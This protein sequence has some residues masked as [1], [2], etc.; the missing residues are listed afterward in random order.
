MINTVPENWIYSDSLEMLFLFYQCTDELL[1]EISPDTY[2]LPQHNTLSLFLEIDE[3]YTLLNEYNIIED[4]YSNY[5]P[6]IIDE[7]IYNLEK[8][9]LLKKLIGK[10]IFTLK[11]G[12][13]EAKKNHVL[14]ER[15]CNLFK[16][17][18][19]PIEYL[20]MYKKE[21][22]KLVVET[23]EKDYLY[24]CTKNLYVSLISLGY[25]REYL[26]TYSKKFFNNKRLPITNLKQIEDFLLEFNV[27]NKKFEFLVLMD[28]SAIEYIDNLGEGKLRIGEKLKKID[29]EDR[30]TYINDICVTDM[31]KQYDKIV[32]NSK[33]SKSLAIMHYCDEGLDPY[34]L[35]VDF[36]NRMYFFQIFD[37]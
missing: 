16:Q 12:F 30:K 1:S 9:K 2:S 28:L 35:A 14:L 5:I 33:N 3:V 6:P 10:R 18:C 26:Y 36:D 25:S 21:I 32:Y 8:D 37:R 4:Y 22:I 23:K 34:S 24:Y 17:I 31:F 20:N 29:I 7:F 13:E 27:K 19:S 11:T 15:W